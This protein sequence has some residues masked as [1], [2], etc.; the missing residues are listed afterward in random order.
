[1][2][3]AWPGALERV[4][5][6]P[7]A[8]VIAGLVVAIA[9]GCTWA[10][11]GTDAWCADSISPRSCGLGA[12]AETYLPGHYHTYPPLQMAVLTVTSLPW[13]A[14]A[15]ARVGGGLDALSAELIKPLYMTGVEAGARLVT[16]LMAVGVV[17]NTMRLWTRIA[18]RRVGVAAGAVQATNAVFV[19][20]AHTG[21]L[22]VPY[23]F[24]VTWV[25]VELDRVA[26]GEP[27]EREALLVAAAAALTKQTAVAALLLPLPLY[28]I[29]IPWLSAR[30]R[31]LR[32]DLL[33]ACGVAALVYAVVSGALVN[34]TGYRRHL[35]FTFGAG[36]QTWANYPPG[37]AGALFLAR[38]TFLSIPRFT[39]W[40][41]A[42]AAIGGVAWSAVS[43]RGL[44]RTR[45]FLPLVAALS[46]M[47]FLHF[48]AR[49]TEE[50]FLL[51]A[52]VALLPYA[53]VAF[54]GAYASFARSRPALVVGAA[55][56]LAPAVLG[57]ASVDATLLADP[58]YEAERFLDSL[59][60]GTAIE[61]YG[62]P[63]FLPRIPA[64]LVATRPGI[65][66]ISER[67]LIPGVTEI[68]DPALDPRPR[69]PAAIVLATEL[70][71]VEATEP[72]PP[73]P[74]GLMQYR[75]ARS[76]ALFRGLYD[77]SLGYVRAFRGT[78]RLPWPLECRRIHYST[79]GEV[80]IYVRAGAPVAVR[81]VEPGG[82]FLPH[83]VEGAAER[84][85]DR[86]GRV[87]HQEVV[88]SVADPSQ[89][90]LLLHDLLGADARSSVAASPRDIGRLFERPP[91]EI[92]RGGVEDAG[93][94]GER[95]K[96]FAPHARR[97]G[98][99]DL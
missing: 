70:S 22:E 95:S 82:A 60:P 26:A 85:A 84:L 83:Q 8:I 48:F 50:R 91:R 36:S 21:N 16:A 80:W 46:H 57:V 74:F 78:C 87:D 6:R 49:R 53:A 81:D 34:P 99:K 72:P 75:D 2:R 45:I 47:L 94:E 68:V 55:V 77:G 32:R 43:T 63:I 52:F 4:L 37:W 56:A 93:A 69:A 9:V 5:R 67:Q 98:G 54:D 59:A 1:V 17:W 7:S 73:S 44:A 92:A 89:G 13:M 88:V 29:V 19:Y 31:P 33:V 79:A 86:G 71:S 10:L 62:G 40:L 39:S 3:R 90:R 27:R 61:V 28:L 64:K 25:L 20:Y 38:S 24:W 23:L 42:A 30:T 97:P 35:G 12:I 14:L 11:P 15:A 18:N 96:T 58:R 41:I 65:E 76:H 51:P 66:P